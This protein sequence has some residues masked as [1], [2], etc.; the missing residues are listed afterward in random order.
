MHDRKAELEADLAQTPVEY[1]EPLSRALR[2]VEAILNDTDPD[3]L[4]ARTG[5]PLLDKWLDELEAGKT[6]DLT[7]GMD[8]RFLKVED[9]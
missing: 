8:P 5:D 6:P 2:A 1:R 3:D 4:M 7:E 9:G